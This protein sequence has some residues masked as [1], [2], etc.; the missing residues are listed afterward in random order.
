MKKGPLSFFLWVADNNLA[1]SRPSDSG[2]RRVPHDLNAWNRLTTVWTS[3]MQSSMVPTKKQKNSI[4]QPSVGGWGEGRA[5]ERASCEAAT[6]NRNW[7]AL[8]IAP[9][10]G[11]CCK[12]KYRANIIHH[13]IFVFFIYFFHHSSCCKDQF[14]VLILKFGT[15]VIVYQ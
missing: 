6:T 7:A 4:G 11:L 1:Y 10:E 9:V 5:K 14:T 3:Q 8:Y 15:Y 13:L 2:V 12:P